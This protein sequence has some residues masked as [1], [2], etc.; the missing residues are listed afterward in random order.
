MTPMKAPLLA[1]LKRGA[2]RR[3]RVVHE[4]QMRI[5]AP[6]RPKELALD[7]GAGVA[8]DQDSRLGHL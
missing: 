7:E 5:H 1:R 2:A 8:T 3:T 4:L 6:L